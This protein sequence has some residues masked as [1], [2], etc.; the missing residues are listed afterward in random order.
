MRHSNHTI[1]WRRQRLKFALL[2]SLTALVAGCDIPGSDLPQNRH[3][4]HR[5][6]SE[7]TFGT[8]EADINEVGTIGYTQWIDGQ[9]ATPSE[10][11][12]QAYYDARRN[13]LGGVTQVDPLLEAFYTRALASKAQLRNRVALALSEIFVV[14]LL[15][16]SVGE[17]PEMMAVYL[18]LLDKAV[19]G[20]Y[21]DLLESVSTSPAMGY[22]LT[23]L[24]NA[25]EDPSFGTTPDE[26]YAR[27]V[28]QL[29]SIGLVRLKPD[30]TP[31]LDAN[32][33]PIESYTTADVRGLAKVFTGWS[34]RGA[35]EGRA[36]MAAAWPRRTGNPVSLWP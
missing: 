26:N 34:R 20:T 10:T 2:M 17:E 28:M 5:F 27:E 12:Y 9:L 6:L 32:G 13:E 36:A 29:F 1:H 16:S 8:S 14:S 18:D 15:D 22:Y 30:G 11:S 33:S 35:W 21:R 31:E 25:K 7:A 19:D 4:A 3:E 24:G 23:F